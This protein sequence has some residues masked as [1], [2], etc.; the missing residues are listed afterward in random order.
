MNIGENIK[1]QRQSKSYSLQQ[2]ADLAGLSKA[3]I[4]QYEDG[5]IQ[6]SSKALQAIAKALHVAF[7]SFFNVEEIQLTLAEFRHGEKIPDTEFERTQIFD[8]VAAYSRS[9]LEIETLLNAQVDFINP[10][11]DFA[12]ANF[13]DAE[14]AAIKLRKKWKLYHLPIDDICGMLESRGF[15]VISFDRNTDSPGLCGFINEGDRIIPFIILNDY[16]EH[17]REITRKRFTIAHELAH[18]TI[19]FADNLT[20]EFKERLCNRFASAFLLPA[21]A[22]TEFLGTNRISISLEELKALKQNYGL[23]VMSI[24]FRASEIGLITT[25]VC[26]QWIGDYNEWRNAGKDFGQYHKSSEDTS[27]LH[28]LISRAL[29]EKRISKE[30]VAEL[31]HIPLDKIDERFG[32]DWFN[33]I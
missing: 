24:I 31:F 15:K 32:N 22:L 7:W 12:V 26:Q 3:S 4:Q 10:I 28:R 27:R 25:A 19:K 11:E 29:S 13:A 16:S 5:T 1:Q 9:Y 17:V 2:L 21:D 8:R 23:S 20:D 30:K 18:L 33:L 6:P 14:N